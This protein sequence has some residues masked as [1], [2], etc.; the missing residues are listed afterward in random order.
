MENPLIGLKKISKIFITFELFFTFSFNNDMN[1]LF[2]TTNFVGKTWGLDWPPDL[3]LY[4][5]DQ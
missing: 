4:V 5:R 3:K 2:P 1:T